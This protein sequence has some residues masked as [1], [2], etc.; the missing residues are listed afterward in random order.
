MVN[1]IKFR[2]VSTS[3]ME[4][5][6]KLRLNCLKDFPQ[7][8]GTLYKE[9]IESANFK[10]DKIINQK[11][12]TDFLMGAFKND[13]LIGICGFI[14]EKREK[15]KHIGAISGMY[16]LTEFSGQKIGTGLL[17]ATIKLAFGNSEIEQIMLAVTGKNQS[18]KHLYEK[19]NFTEYGRLPQYFKFNNEYETQILMVLTKT[20]Y[21]LANR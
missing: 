12:T 18:A 14:Q 8:F 20:K 21:K 10:F 5:Y 4:D 13:E 1:E 6:H 3:E 9:E 15:T 17:D 2:K 11:A 16:V 19:F 7:N